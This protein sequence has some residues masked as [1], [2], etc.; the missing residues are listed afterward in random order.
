VDPLHIPTR[1]GDDILKP[2]KVM[3]KKVNINNNNMNKNNN[4]NN[5]NNTDE[6][7]Q[8]QKNIPMI[9]ECPNK[10]NTDEIIQ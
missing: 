6:T 8:Q 5:K 4:N 9:W 2:K 10:N 7:L 1:F 3:D